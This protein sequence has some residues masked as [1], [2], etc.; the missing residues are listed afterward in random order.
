MEW[1]LLINASCALLIALANFSVFWKREIS[2]NTGPPFY[3]ATFAKKVAPLNPVSRQ[4]QLE[5][6]LE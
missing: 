3:T 6:K 2:G 5:M 4:K 1:L